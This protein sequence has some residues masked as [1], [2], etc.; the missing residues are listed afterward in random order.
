M[1]TKVNLISGRTIVQGQNLDNKL[2]E[3]YFNEVA[4]CELNGSDMEKLGVAADERVK[5]KTNYGEVVVKAKEKA[6]TPE[7]VIFIPMGPWANA[8]VSGDTHG[9][10]M[11]SYKGIDAEIEPT[12]EEVLQVKALMKTYMK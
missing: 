2:S 4:T 3:A 10:G 6:G 9:A 11:P 7:G 1:G 5:I 12:E 8:L